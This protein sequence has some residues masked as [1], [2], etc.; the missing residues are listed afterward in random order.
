MM[1]Y[2]A[3]SG[4][5]FMW[6]SKPLYVRMEAFTHEICWMCHIRQRWQVNVLLHAHGIARACVASSP[7]LDCKHWSW[8]CGEWVEEAAVVVVAQAFSLVGAQGNEEVVHST[9]KIHWSSEICVVDGRADRIDPFFVQKVLFDTDTAREAGRRSMWWTLQVIA[10]CQPRFAALWNHILDGE[11]TEWTF[12]FWERTVNVVV[13]ALSIEFMKT[14]TNVDSQRIPR[15]KAPDQGVT[16]FPYVIGLDSSKM[17]RTAE[18]SKICLRRRSGDRSP[19]S[20]RFW[21]RHR[22]VVQTLTCPRSP[23]WQFHFRIFAHL[24][25]MHVPFG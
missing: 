1:E 21:R 9:W 25:E 24:F 3:P 4:C 2:P 13:L 5:F 10:R 23:C 19:R 8:H 16:H 18:I 20:S 17:W 12:C 7:A 6:N 15:W 22:E 14:G 11:R